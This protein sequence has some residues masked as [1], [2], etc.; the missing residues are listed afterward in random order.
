M[1]A[2]GEDPHDSSEEIE[3]DHQRWVRPHGAEAQSFYPVKEDL[4]GQELVREARRTVEKLI[5]AARQ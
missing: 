5:Q 2:H 4:P 3:I 1:R